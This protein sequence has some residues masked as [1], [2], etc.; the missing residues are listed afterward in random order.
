MTYREAEEK[1]ILLSVVDG[2]TWFVMDCGPIDRSVYE[3]HP[4]G[5]L[6]DADMVAYAVN[7]KAT[8]IA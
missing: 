8:V 5:E 7:G 2:R 1:A 4:K 6:P 3:V